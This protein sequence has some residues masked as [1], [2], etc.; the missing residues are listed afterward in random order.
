[1]ADAPPGPEEAVVTHMIEDDS[2]QAQ[3]EFL[4]DFREKIVKAATTPE[5]DTETVD[6]GPY[7]EGT[8]TVHRL[9]ITLR[10][11]K[12]S[13]WRRI[14][15]ASDTILGELSSMIKNSIPDSG[16]KVFGETA[17]QDLTSQLQDHLD[18]TADD[19]L[20]QSVISLKRLIDASGAQLLAG[21]TSGRSSYQRWKPGDVKL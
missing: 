13:V 3:L 19:E 14:E 21:G 9:K 20:E 17:H 4:A 8:K 15:V 1:V 7:P 18:G 5:V 16:V 11:V 6:S 12:P 10:S 2:V